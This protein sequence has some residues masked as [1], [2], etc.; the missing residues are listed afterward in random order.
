VIS[1]IVYNYY[2][3]KG[4]EI[5]YINPDDFFMHKVLQTRKGNTLSNGVLYLV[6][7]ELLAI[8]VK[9]INIPKQFVLAF[10]NEDYDPVLITATPRKKYIFI[11]M[12]P[13]GNPSHKKMWRIILSV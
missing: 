5:A 3:L 10:F 6:L 9:A 13:R 8:P 12:L 7:A 1:S 4:S 11:L 2:N